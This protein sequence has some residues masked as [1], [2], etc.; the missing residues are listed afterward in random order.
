MGVGAGTLVSPIYIS[1][2]SPASLR[3]ML[4]SGYQVFVQAGALIGFW[5]AFIAQAVLADKSALQWQI[6]VSLQ[7]VVGGMLLLGTLLIP[8]SPRYFGRAGPT[9]SHGS[10]SRLATAT[11]S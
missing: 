2:I 11:I 1:E 5:I 10:S 7:L 6:P 3:G 8:E 4:M 9:P